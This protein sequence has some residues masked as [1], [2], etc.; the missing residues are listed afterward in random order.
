[1]P[2]WDNSPR[3]AN[4]A[5]ILVDST[6]DAYREWL[7]ETVAK[8][9]PGNTDENLVFIN[10]WNE[11]GEG[12]HLEPDQRWRHRYLE[13]HLAVRETW[14]LAADAERAVDPGRGLIAGETG[15]HVRITPE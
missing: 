6:P 9:D 2:S 14:Q 13:A 5:L 4:D 7:V 12:N 15:M 8:F 10:A 3:R 1:M 11:W